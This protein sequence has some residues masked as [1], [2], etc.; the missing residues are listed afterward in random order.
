MFKQWA[1]S[2]IES[3]K[4][5]GF[6]TNL[7]NNATNDADDSDSDEEGDD[8]DS[9]CAGCDKIL[10]DCAQQLFS[11]VG[12]VL[13]EMFAGKEEPGIEQI[14]DDL[15]VNDTLIDN[16]LSDVHTVCSFRLFSKMEEKILKKTRLMFRQLQLRFRYGIPNVFRGLKVLFS[17]AF[18]NVPFISDAESG[19]RL[20]PVRPESLWLKWANSLVAQVGWVLEDN[21]HTDPDPSAEYAVHRKHF[22]G[23]NP[24]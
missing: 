5:L 9:C 6:E 11:F 22:C 13:S 24:A 16:R 12:R 10:T 7:S 20:V 17:L 15:L 8:H 18:L 21:A 4:S 1:I 3:M 2:S 19:P 23:T 14:V